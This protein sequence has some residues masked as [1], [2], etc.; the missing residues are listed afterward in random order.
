MQ[1]LIF[2]YLLLA[3]LIACGQST[4]SNLPHYSL[5]IGMGEATEEGLVLVSTGHGATARYRLGFF[6]ANAIYRQRS[7]SAPLFRELSSSFFSYYR[8]QKRRES[9]RPFC[10]RQLRSVERKNGVR[11]VRTLCIDEL[12]LS[13]QQELGNWF[14]LV[15]SL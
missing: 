15:R 3:A 13:A 4:S 7:I 10:D 1:K 9:L 2:V 8:R 12:S 11:H 5:V 14:R 6:G